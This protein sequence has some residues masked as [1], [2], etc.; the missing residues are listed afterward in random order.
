[1]QK[2]LEGFQTRPRSQ[3]EAS[4]V[5]SKAEPWTPEKK[6]GKVNSPGPRPH[7]PQILSIFSWTPNPNPTNNNFS[8]PIPA[9]AINRF[10]LQ[11]SWVW[12]LE[13]TRQLIQNLWHRQ[14]IAQLASLH[15]YTIIPL[16]SSLIVKL[17]STTGHILMVFMWL[18][19]SSI[20][21]Q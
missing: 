10:S 19:G 15:R 13:G 20:Q 2:K 3:G 14:L 9:L 7:I 1:M 16:K 6:L 4:V 11:F 21:W 12:I 8:Q 18:T 5:W 17:R